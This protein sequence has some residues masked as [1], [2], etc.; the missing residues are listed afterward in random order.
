LNTN[1]FLS[2]S[3]IYVIPLLICLLWF[4]YKIWY[5]SRNNEY[6]QKLTSEQL[7]RRPKIVIVGGGFAGLSLCRNL[8][9]DPNIDLTLVNSSNYVEYIPGILRVLLYP[10][11]FS[12]LHMSLRKILGKNIKFIHGEIQQILH[13][14]ET[15]SGT[16]LVQTD[17]QYYS[18]RIKQS[19]ETEN[20]LNTL[21]NKNSQLSS[22]LQKIPYDILVLSTGSSYPAPIKGNPTIDNIITTE[23]R[24]K[25]INQASID[26]ENAKSILIVGGGPVGIELAGEL[27][28]KYCP[29][30]NPEKAK[31]I[32][33]VTAGK[34]LLDGF[35]PILGNAAYQWLK[36]RKVTIHTNLRLPS[37]QPH[38]KYPMLNSLSSTT[39]PTTTTSNNIVYPGLQPKDTRINTSDPN[40]LIPAD[41][42]FACI[43]SRPSSTY[44]KSNPNNVSPTNILHTAYLPSGKISVDDAFQLRSHDGQVFP[45]VF[46]LGD[47]SAPLFR[48]ADVAYVAEKHSL[49]VLQNIK[50]YSKAIQEENQSRKTNIQLYEYPKDIPGTLS[51][52]QIFC[53][54]LGPYYALL[55]FNKLSIGTTKYSQ[56]FIAII[57]RIIELTK[58]LQLRNHWFGNYFWIIAD[59]G[60]E[61]TSH[62]LFPPAPLLSNSHHP[63][64]PTTKQN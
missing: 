10:S 56:K 50:I 20:S 7:K 64:H 49:C 33:L 42:V 41:Y 36:E 40:I 18:N 29:Y 62:Y 16:I 59:W 11:L 5:Q 35:D 31:H 6:P 46:A 4:V 25:Q 17:P 1:L 39:I 61:I 58:V 21:S 57:K 38:G 63:Q 9:N 23:D 45:R 19:N 15:Y 55:A 48:E 60:A 8:E 13:D 44:L 2:I 28:T 12:H 51:S 27:L 30:R 43:G 53:I 14:T 47:V 24:L 26:I 54:S 52:P 3:F 32:T 34:Q 22:S 37:F